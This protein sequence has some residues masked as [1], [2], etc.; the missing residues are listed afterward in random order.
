MSK[1]VRKSSPVGIED[2]MALNDE[3]IALLKAGVP[4]ELGLSELGED[5]VSALGQLASQL[6]NQLK[7]G[8]SLTDALADP[9]LGVP[10]SYRVIVEAG[11]KAERLTTALEGVSRMARK[12]VELRKR[13]GLALVYPLIVLMLAYGLFVLFCTHITPRLYAS[14]DSFG[15]SAG[16]LLKLLYQ[17]GRDV[18]LWGWILPAIVVAFCVWWRYVSQRGFLSCDGTLSKLRWCCPGVGKIV[19]FYRYSQFAELLALLIEHDVPLSEAIVLASDTTNDV[20]MQE[21]ARAIAEVAT[22]GEW[23]PNALPGYSGFPPYLHWLITR[24][25]EQQGIVS[26]LK[27]A[28]DM[29]RRRAVVL[30]EWI[31]VVFPA[32]AAVFIG[33]SATLIY[34]LTVFW[35]LT[36]LLRTLS[37]PTI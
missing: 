31:K 36:E 17:M 6:A 22:R 29:Y 18:L 11:L 27:S 37:L 4:L 20:V 10:R 28:A 35:P 13:I 33:G 30:T 23:I 7:Q 1:P 19:K 5:R 16:W 3:M 14:V 25:G 34:T 21:A 2:L 24:R 15:V 26:A 8:Q 9:T 12:M 32:L